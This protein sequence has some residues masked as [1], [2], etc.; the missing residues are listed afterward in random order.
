MLQSLCNFRHIS[1]NYVKQWCRKKCLRNFSVMCYEAMTDKGQ[2]IIQSETTSSSFL[3]S[4]PAL[5]FVSFLFHH[6][7]EDMWGGALCQVSQKKTL[8]QGLTSKWLIM[9]GLPGQTGEVGGETEQARRRSR[10]RVSSQI[11]TTD[12][13][14]SLNPWG[15]LE[16][17]FQP[18][19]IPS[20]S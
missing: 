17:R 10:A 19:I 13:S 2:S 14:F 11:K 16:G 1:T 20:Q 3:S 8:Q 18:I 9:P 12:G 15:A 4:L 7:Q 6:R 5:L